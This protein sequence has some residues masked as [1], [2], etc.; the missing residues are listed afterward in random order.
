MD[1]DSDDS[2]YN[3]TYEFDNDNK[4]CEYGNDLYSYKTN[5]KENVKQYY[6]HHKYGEYKYKALPTKPKQSRKC[7]TIQSSVSRDRGK[8]IVKQINI[9]AIG[10][11]KL[12]K[13]KM[14]CLKCATK[15]KSD[16]CNLVK[17]INKNTGN[18]RYRIIRSCGL[19]GS[20][21]CRYVK[22]DIV[23]SYI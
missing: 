8:S 21:S 11:G 9:N 13:H 6:D 16:G 3:D 22:K 23:E 5:N 18:F 12:T 19:C 7:T 17:D 10:L 20:K 2:S 4:C 14:Y 15:T 1:I